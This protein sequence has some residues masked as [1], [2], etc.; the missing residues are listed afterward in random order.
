MGLGGLPHREQKGGR[1]FDAP[2]VAAPLSSPPGHVP[3]PAR[4]PSGSQLRERRPHAQ[5]LRKIKVAQRLACLQVVL[6]KLV[7]LQLAVTGRVR[8]REDR[9]LHRDGLLVL[10]RR[11]REELVDLE[12]AVVVDIA[13]M[14]SVAQERASVDPRSFQHHRQP[15]QEYRVVKD[16]S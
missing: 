4:L 15:R 3:S 16:G 5:L 7:L 13:P 1:G 8:L 9:L 11:E 6:H 12:H 14:E 10:R 2:N